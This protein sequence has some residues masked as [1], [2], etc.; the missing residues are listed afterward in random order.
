[1]RF[2]LTALAAQGRDVKLAESRIEGYRNFCTKIWNA[3][4][5]CEMNDCRY[6]ADYDP[7]ANTQ[8]VN[9]WIVSQLA[10]VEPQVRRGIEDYRFNEAAQAC[11]QFIWNTYCDWYLEFAKPLFQGSDEAAKAE[12]R[13]T[14]LW[15]LH[16]ALFLLHPIMPF[17]TE[18]LWQQSGGGEERLMLLSDWPSFD[19]GLID[20]EA[21]A[22]LGWAVRLISQIRALRS[23]MNVPPSATAPLVM[24]DAAPLTLERLERHGEAIRRLARVSDITEKNEAPKGSAQ[25]VVGEATACLPLGDLIDLKAEAARLEKEIAKLDGEISR[26]QKKLANEKF[27][28]R[29][30]DDIV[31]SEREKMAEFQGSRDRLKTAHA[32]V[33]EAG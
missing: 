7:A 25:I 6:G 33:A 20:A 32:R 19:A 14:A 30:P 12:T 11:Y 27:V 10:Q 18:E 29:A 2:T 3:A 9:R 26:I 22:S 28:A 23:E 15:V 24:V 5:F 21:D 17:L 31:A 8:R 13:A 1:V 4:R 16:Q